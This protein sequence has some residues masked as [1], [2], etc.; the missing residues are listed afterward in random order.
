M[1]LAVEVWNREDLIAH[2]KDKLAPW[3]D[4][5]EGPA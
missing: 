3:P 2:L 5:D 4:L 1:A